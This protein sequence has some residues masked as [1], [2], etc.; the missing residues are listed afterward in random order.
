[1]CMNQ[2]NQIEYMINQYKLCPRFDLPQESSPTEVAWAAY[3]SLL[4]LPKQASTTRTKEW[5]CGKPNKIQPH[6]GMVVF[7]H[8]V[9]WGL[10]WIYHDVSTVRWVCKPHFNWVCLK[11]L[12]Q[13]WFMI[14]GSSQ[15]PHW[16]RLNPHLCFS[17]HAIWFS[18]YKQYVN[19]PSKGWHK[20]M[21]GCLKKLAPNMSCFESPFS[22][23]N[24]Y[25]YI[26]IKPHPTNHSRTSTHT[27]K[28]CASTIYR[29]INTVIANLTTGVIPFIVS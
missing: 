29:V 3:N 18:C 22:L 16:S 8:L 10:R 28:W 11:R 26:Y 7:F 15:H 2:T 24:I 9:Y 23:T 4:N 25:I 12:N 13:G 14:S 21:W 17:T 5:T 27:S 1:M 6:M 20:N 19:L